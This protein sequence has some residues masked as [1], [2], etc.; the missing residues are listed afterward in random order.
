MLPGVFKGRTLVV[1]R[2]S[3]AGCAQLIQNYQQVGAHVMEPDAF[4]TGTSAKD[5]FDTIMVFSTDSSEAPALDFFSKCS[6]VL[7][8]SGGFSMRYL[9]DDADAFEAIASKNIMYAGLQVDEVKKGDTGSGKRNVLISGS[10]PSWGLGA[11]SGLDGDAALIDDS[12]LID[13]N[14]NYEAMGAGKESCASK[15]RACANCSCGRAELEKDLGAEEAKRR[16]EQGVQ[17]SSC[18]NCYLGDAFRCAACPYKGKP[19]F[20]PG[21]KVE[22]DTDTSN[23]GQAAFTAGAEDTAA[24]TTNGA[25]KLQM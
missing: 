22:L 25:V 20:K 8:P 17:R 11:A 2:S 1:A 10:K 16:L 4:M 13:T 3:D 14:E 18:G 24:A 9:V 15:P 21:Q 5:Q 23:S 12:T 19:A 7:K 6:T